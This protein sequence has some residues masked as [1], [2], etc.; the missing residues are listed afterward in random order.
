MDVQQERVQ[1]L[2]EWIIYFQFAQAK[3]KKVLRWKEGGGML[4]LHEHS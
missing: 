1:E 2:N 4:D 3:V